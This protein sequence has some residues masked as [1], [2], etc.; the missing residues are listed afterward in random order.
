MITH[1]S[2]NPETHNLVKKI[3]CLLAVF[4]AGLTISGLT[5]FP[6]QTELDVATELI[7][8]YQWNNPVSQWLLQ[9]SQ[10]VSETNARFPFMAY[11]TDWLAFA[12]LVL[13]IAFV[14]PLR[15]PV[16]NIWVIEFGLIACALIIPL[17]LV[18]GEVRGIPLF[19]RLFDCQFGICGGLIL[20]TC[21]RSTKD[22]ESLTK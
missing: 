4:I 1:Q 20:M 5:A 2:P 9:A 21:Y 6:I 22:L 18:A 8:K 14:G 16:R 3:K 15:D 10:G 11:G 19:W 13:A 17:A 12:H 7:R